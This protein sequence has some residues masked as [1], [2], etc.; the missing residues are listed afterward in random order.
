MKVAPR[1]NGA[2]RAAVAHSQGIPQKGLGHT[3]MQY[4]GSVDLASPLS[5]S[6]GTLSS[7]GA[8]IGIPSLPTPAEPSSISIPHDPL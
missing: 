3:N 1:A 2:E 6:M 4:A 7:L 8:S 5:E